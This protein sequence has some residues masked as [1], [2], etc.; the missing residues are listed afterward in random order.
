MKTTYILKMENKNNINKLIKYHVRFM[1][2]KYM[3]DTC[4]LYVDEENYSKLLKFFDIY[5]I[6]L[7]EVKGLLKYQLLL[8]K[9]YIFFISVLLGILLVYFLSNIIFDIRIMTNKKDLIKIIN[10]ELEEYGLVKYRFIKSFEEK[11]EIKKKIL[12]NYKDKFEWLEIERVGTRYYIKVLERIINQQEDVET[13]RNVI[14]K[15]NAIILEIKASN[16]QIIKKVNDYV[17]K[18]DIIISGNITKKDE[19]KQKVK[20]SGT[21]YGETWYT[22][23][24]QL[25]HTYEKKIYTGNSYKRLTINIFN[26]K[27]FLFGKKN[28]QKEEEDEQIL[29]D[30]K[31]LPISL[32]KTEILEIKSSKAIY[33]Y[34]EA[35]NKGLDIA[36]K[37]LMDYLSGNCQILE[38]KKLKLYEEDST[39]I[40][41]VFFKVYEEITDYNNI[42]VEGE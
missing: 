4:F 26:Q 34:D 15:K 8:K 12:N 41:E 42:S 5:Q 24:V 37:K 10:N 1:K 32:S 3:N 20:A 7:I 13:Y 33:T 40:I 31:I 11:E 27:I 14:A 21:V 38:Q 22:V 2:I 35:L 25:P 36:R 19:I 6:S 39:I 29:L 23:Q 16:G 9:Y 28:Y 18:G 30:S 17:N